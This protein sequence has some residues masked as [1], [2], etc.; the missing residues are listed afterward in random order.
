MK[1]KPIIL[2]IP[3]PQGELEI[4]FAIFCRSMAKQHIAGFDVLPHQILRVLFDT[5]TVTFTTRDQRTMLLKFEK[6]LDVFVVEF[7]EL[8]GGVAVIIK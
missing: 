4:S 2:H 6:L 8:V 7:F 1:T 3:R 5:G